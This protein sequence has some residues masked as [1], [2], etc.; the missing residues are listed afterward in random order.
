[1]RKELVPEMNGKILV[2]AAQTSDEMV[3]EGANG[4]FGSIAAMHA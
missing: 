2:H 4:A 3:F 1:M